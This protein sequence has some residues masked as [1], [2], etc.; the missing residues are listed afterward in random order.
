MAAFQISGAVT[1]IENWFVSSGLGD[2]K[3]RLVSTKPA[4]LELNIPG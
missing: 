3:D 4:E 2:G 1:R